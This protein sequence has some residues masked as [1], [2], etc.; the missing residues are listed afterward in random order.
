MSML[1]A[2]SFGNW[3]APRQMMTLGRLFNL[4]PIAGVTVGRHGSR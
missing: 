2:A 4:A 3:D 1:I